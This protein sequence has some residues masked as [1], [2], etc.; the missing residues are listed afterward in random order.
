[1]KVSYDFDPDWTVKDGRGWLNSDW[2][3][4]VDGVKYWIP[5]LIYDID[6]AS[7]PWLFRKIP[8]IG[9]PFDKDNLTGA[10][11]HDP[12]F[13]THVL[14][15]EGANEVAR[16][17]WILSGKSKQAAG[18]MKTAVSSPFGRVSYYNTQKDIEELQK[19]RQ[20]IKWR[21]DWKKFEPM[22]FSMAA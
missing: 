4:I 20:Q 12:L 14:G 7:I 19:I 1:M 5:A 15:F 8:F 18:I 17:L 22:W 6:G 21:D 13:L 10:G 9:R 16:Q 2:Y 3:F 11:A